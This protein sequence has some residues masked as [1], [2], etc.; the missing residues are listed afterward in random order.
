MSDFFLIN[1]TDESDTIVEAIHSLSGLDYNQYDIVAEAVK[2][3]SASCMIN[4]IGN[5]AKVALELK[6]S[7]LEGLKD[8]DPMDVECDEYQDR[9]VATYPL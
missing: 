3:V 1:Q 5:Y 8:V 4:T 6:I 2:Q 9:P 7:Y